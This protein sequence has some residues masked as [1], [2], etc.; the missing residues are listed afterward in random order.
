[1]PIHI[2]P[3]FRSLEKNVLESSGIFYTLNS[4]GY[5]VQ[6]AEETAGTKPTPPAD[7]F[8][9]VIYEGSSTELTLP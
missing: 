1:M 8:K 2:H 9:K 3:Y 5:T 4:L 6:L 7:L